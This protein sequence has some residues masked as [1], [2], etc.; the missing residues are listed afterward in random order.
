M[1]LGDI[2]PK[3]K[4]ISFEMINKI[5]TKKESQRFLKVVQNLKK[6]KSGHLDK[7]NI[8]IS[9]KKIKRN[10]KKSIF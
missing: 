7:L 2:L 10:N 9:N 6:I 5:L 8:V 3:N 4:N 1:I